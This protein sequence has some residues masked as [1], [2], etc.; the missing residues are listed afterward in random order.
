[1]FC[2]KGTKA[3]AKQLRIVLRHGIRPDFLEIHLLSENYQQLLGNQRDKEKTV[4]TSRRK[5]ERQKPPTFP[6]T[7]ADSEVC[8][9]TLQF[10]VLCRKQQN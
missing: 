4:E 8:S 6:P 5:R 10:G 2:F 3:K 9:V 1:M 7:S